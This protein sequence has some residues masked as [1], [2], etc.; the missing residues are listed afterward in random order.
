MAIEPPFGN[1]IGPGDP[2]VAEIDRVVQK[3]RQRPGRAGSTADV[4]VQGQAQE[5]AFVTQ[6]VDVVAPELGRLLGRQQV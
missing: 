6:H 1:M 4:R 2:D 5:L 3:E